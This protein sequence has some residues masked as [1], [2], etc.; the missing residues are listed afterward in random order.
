MQIV[1]E[2][3][4]RDKDPVGLELLLELQK[5]YDGYGWCEVYRIDEEGIP[6]YRVKETV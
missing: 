4:K 1:V 5:V 3:Y 6:H 2:S